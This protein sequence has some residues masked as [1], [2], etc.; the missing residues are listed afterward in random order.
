M[1]QKVVK[2]SEKTI[3][4][5]R[6]IL[7]AD[8]KL[9]YEAERHLINQPFFFEGT[10]GKCVLLVHGWTST[11]YEVRR[12][13]EYLNSEGFAVSGPMLRGHGTK[14]E[15]LEDVKL[16]D[17]LSDLL[18][19]FDELKERYS[20]VYVGGTSVGS[21]LAILLATRRP[22]IRGLILMAMPYKIKLEKTMEFWGKI[23]LFLG[24][25]YNKKYYPP[26]FGV[27]T[28]IT[29]LI[30]YQKYSVKS[31][32]E[33]LRLI[34]ISRE[35]I[36]Q[37]KQP[38]FLIQSKQDHVVSHGSLDK[39]YAQIGSQVKRKKYINRAYHTFISDI[40][41]EYVFQD[42]LEFLKNN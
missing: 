37:V 28:T 12:L 22:E 36:S 6:S 4:K 9:L 19:T 34:K 35:N 16:E 1:I 41:N 25:K 33:A 27:S 26:T 39:I 30:S 5:V 38:C 13:G 32:T 40:K 8:P 18:K 11:A 10:N 21:N 17:W 31:A 14:P 15:D 3:G 7:F 24:I 20:D 2:L 23:L 42:I 29:R